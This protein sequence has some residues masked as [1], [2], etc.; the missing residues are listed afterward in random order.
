MSTKPEYDDPSDQQI[1]EETADALWRARH[2]PEIYDQALDI[3][4]LSGIPIDFVLESCIAAE[5]AKTHAEL[6]KAM[7]RLEIVIDTVGVH[8][9]DLRAI[10]RRNR[11]TTL[12]CLGS[13]C[14]RAVIDK[15]QPPDPDRFDAGRI[16]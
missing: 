14:V 1:A 12:R 3:A 16:C 6:Y 8:R 5:R 9:P 7:A 2:M 10:M 13:A 4:I 15:A 11:V